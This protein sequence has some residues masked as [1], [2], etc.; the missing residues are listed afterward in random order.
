MDARKL[1]LVVN[2]VAPQYMQTEKTD[3]VEYKG[4]MRKTP[5]TSGKQLKNHRARSTV[6]GTG[7]AS[8][9]RQG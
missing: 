7:S 3:V 8:L 9:C 6:D 1:L 5:T 2:A 4:F